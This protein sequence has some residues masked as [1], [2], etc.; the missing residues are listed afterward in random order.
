MYSAMEQLPALIF[1]GNEH[2]VIAVCVNVQQNMIRNV[3]LNL[4]YLNSQTGVS[5]D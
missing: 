3:S 4:Q 2:R 1:A 5:G